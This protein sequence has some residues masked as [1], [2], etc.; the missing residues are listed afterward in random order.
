MGIF[1][2]LGFLSK[3]AAVYF[4]ICLLL[5]IF[6]FKNYRKIFFNNIFGFSL[7]LLCA[8]IIIIPN[9]IWNINND[10]MTIQH[11]SDNANFK[12]ID[13]DLL[14]GLEFL[15]LQLFMIGPI[16]FLGGVIHILRVN[17]TQKLLLVFSLPII[18]IV[19]LEA[20]IVRANA[21]WAAPALISLFVCLYVGMQNSVFKTINFLFNFSFFK[22]FFIMIG[23][24]YPSN[25]FNRVNGLNEY[26]NKIFN[27]ISDGSVEN[28]VVS[29]RLLFSSLS[30]ELRNKKISFYMPHKKGTEITNH[31]K[32]MSPLKEKMKKDF[33]LIGT[34]TDINYLENEYILIKK[35]SPAQ[36]FTNKKL[37]V[38]EVVFK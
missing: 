25:L 27:T 11:T 37:D 34:P 38:Y 22:I 9:I 15:L 14:R 6:I 29:D 17:Y 12:N 3:Y 23:M 32:M 19:F 33:I 7:S 5:L 36:K 8:L 31:F 20:V 28:I 35:N 2:G 30:Y 24:S 26:A 1:I 10:W 18:F 21:N 13:I 16:L 4:L